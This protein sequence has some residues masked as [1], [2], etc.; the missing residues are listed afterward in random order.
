M[1]TGH[2][3]GP[4]RTANSKQIFPEKELRALSPNF[5]I[6]VSV[7]D[8][9]IPN[10][11]SGYFDTK[12]MLTDPGNIYIAHRHM[13]V[14]IGTEAAQLLFWEYINETIF[15]AVRVILNHI[16]VGLIPFNPTKILLTFTVAGFR[17]LYFSST[18]SYCR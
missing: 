2:G 12:N 10:D 15:I 13:N 9:Y 18:N 5:R 14:E 1:S 4:H 8:L 6:H 3:V 17:H 7:S 11:R 16:A